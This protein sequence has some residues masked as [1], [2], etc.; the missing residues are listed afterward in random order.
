MIQETEKRLAL[1]EAFSHSLFDNEFKSESDNLSEEIDILISMREVSWRC[2]LNKAEDFA[3]CLE[4][5]TAGLKQCFERL[6]ACIESMDVMSEE[7]KLFF[8]TRLENFWAAANLSS[9]YE[10]SLYKIVEAYNCQ[11]MG[12][13]YSLAREGFR[14]KE[15][16]MGGY[17]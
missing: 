11:R 9:F 3:S 14:F 8:M 10:N 12:L 2:F 5:M 7:D 17:F 6:D 16:V 4:E 13:F 1:K 15:L